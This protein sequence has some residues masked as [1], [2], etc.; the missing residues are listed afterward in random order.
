M[1]PGSYSNLDMGKAIE[2]VITHPASKG[3]ILEVHGKDMEKVSQTG[4]V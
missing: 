3:Q 1:K 2:G 4:T